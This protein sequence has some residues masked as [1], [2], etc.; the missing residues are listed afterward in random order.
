MSRIMPGTGVGSHA[1][2]APVHRLADRPIQPPP[3][4]RKKAIEDEVQALESAAEFVQALL[5]DRAAAAAGETADILS[6]LS[7]FAADPA[8]MMAAKAEVNNGWDAPTAISRA[9]KSFAQMLQSAGGAFAERA[10]DLDEIALRIT[11]RLTGQEWSVE[12]PAT[13]RYVLVAEDLTPA[14]TAQIDPKIV[15][16]VVTQKGGPTSHTSII[17]RQKGIAAVVGCT[18]ALELVNGDLVLVDPVGDRIVLNGDLTDA[19]AAL[20]TVDPDAPTLIPVYGNIG[21]QKDAQAVVA[22]H[23]AGVGLFRTELLYLDADTAPT[24]AEQRKIYE[25]VFAELG[26]RPIVIRTL[27][28]GSD[29]PLRFLNLASEENPALGVRGWRIA[30]PQP[31]VVFDQLTAIKQAADST[32][33][34][35]RVMAPM[36]SIPQEAHQFAAMAREVGLKHIGIMIET[37]AIA[38]AVR[39]LAGHLDFVS[40]GTN[41]LAQYLFAADRQHNEL[42]EFLDPWQ[43]ALLRTIK[44]I[45]DDAARINIAVGVCG[46]AAADPLLAIVLAGIGVNSVSAAAPAI[47]GVRTRLALVDQATA[48]QAAEVAMKATSPSQAKASVKALIA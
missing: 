37:P 15:V 32:G 45:C 36:I 11:A 4:R 42:V 48:I 17:C 30:G 29:K 7:A 35:V 9:S 25:G 46:E 1:V 19:T 27:D 33:A 13:G 28:A 24:I 38:F 8:L 6:A 18:A 39:D 40:I 26:E 23:G 41:D 47:P 20:P 3:T 2:V 14:D 22:M 43:P 10:A 31:Q 44:R 16:G 21:N 5:K 34:D 12:I